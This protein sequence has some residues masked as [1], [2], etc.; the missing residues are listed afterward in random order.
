[1]TCGW[2]VSLT[3][4]RVGVQA[5]WRRF[6]KIVIRRSTAW[7]L[8]KMIAGGIF[9]RIPAR[10]RC[11]VGGGIFKWL[12]E[13]RWCAQCNHGPGLTV[14]PSAIKPN[15]ASNLPRRGQKKIGTAVILGTLWSNSAARLTSAPYMF[16]NGCADELE[17]ICENSL[18]EEY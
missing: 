1:M 9:S 3:H 5:N 14:P 4:L 6:G 8:N 17:A 12:C 13:G 18:S 7:I 11:V 15:C 16:S 10:R 2:L